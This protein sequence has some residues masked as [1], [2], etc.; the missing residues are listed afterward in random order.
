MSLAV[1]YRS[2]CRCSIAVAMLLLV[3]AS[4]A[5][6]QSSPR[7]YRSLFGG[8]S[9]GADRDTDWF[10]LTTTEAYDQNVLGDVNAPVQQVL[11]KGGEYT[12]VNAEMNYRADGR[13]VQFASAG[14]TTFRYY[15][16]QNQF[17]GVG[18]HAGAGATINFS[19]STIL[20]L[21]QTAA[22]S[23]SYLYGLFTN[24]AGPELGRVNVGTNYAVT[25]SA[26]YNYD[27]RVTL[28]EQMGPRNSLAVQVGGRYTDFVHSGSAVGGNV[29][30]DLLSY[31]AG[32]TFS[33]GLSRD[34]HLTLG[35][36][37]RRTEYFDGSFPIEHDLNV[38]ILY[39]RPLSRTRRT[40]LRVDTGSVMLHAPAPGDAPGVLRPQYGMTADVALTTQF[41]R[42]WQAEGGYRRGVNYIEGI[43][44]PVL[45]DGLT[46]SVSGLLSPRVNLLVTGAYS[47][48]QPTVADAPHGLTTYTADARTSV[49]LNRTWACFAEY[50]YYYYDFSAGLVPVGAPPHVARNSV[51]VGLMLWVPMRQR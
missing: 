18:H 7:P 36:T 47:V 25:D 4:S 16:D 46:T 24:I 15:R 12:E 20:S 30:R 42:T 40:Y 1:S 43:R 38:G 29:L 26:S 33:R 11:Q 51:R 50:L 23:P 28:T 45:T 3:C 19:P 13:R 2:V 37:F 39:S 21:N 22:Y 41:G 44:T 8:S 35:Y 14:G 10:M 31:E 32:G 17:L 49:A 48:G 34:L 9:S 5:F 27:T 6:A